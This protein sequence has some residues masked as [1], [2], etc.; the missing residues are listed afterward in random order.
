MYEAEKHLEPAPEST[1][2]DYGLAVA[3]VAAL[4]FPFLG[5]GITLFDLVTAPARGKRLNDWCEELRIRLNDLSEKV[6]GLTPEAL[7]TN[8]AFI[9]AFAQATTAAIKTHQKEKL[10]A[11]RS[12]IVNVAL[13]K[14]ANANRQMQFLALVDR[15]TAAHLTLLRFFQDPAGH[16]E[17][18]HLPAPAVPA[19]AFLV[20]DLV[21]MALPELHQELQSLAQDRS[22][23]AFQNFQ[24][25]FDDL[26]SQRLITLHRVKDN[27]AWIVPRFAG[28]PVNPVITDLGEDFL[29][30]ITEPQEAHS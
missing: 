18:R 8:D 3:K 15:F 13:G 14:D 24:G 21:R 19:G 2:F 1:A 25:L 10:D 20:Y 6:K 16:F 26:T 22:A 30:F 5:A 17:R 11:L 23:S 27:E 4:A 9:S 29:A 7:A 12:A 28:Y